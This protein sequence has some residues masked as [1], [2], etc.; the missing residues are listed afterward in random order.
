VC[1]TNTFNIINTFNETTF[2]KEIQTPTYYDVEY[3]YCVRNKTLHIEIGVCGLVDN[4]EL[5]ID[6]DKQLLTIT[7]SRVIRQKFINDISNMNSNRKNG[8]FK[9]NCMLSENEMK[10][11]TF[12]KKSISLE[13]GVLYI[14][15][16]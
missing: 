11:I 14:K 16:K 2:P 7:G 15:I 6:N 12:T 10:M 5:E 3:S 9:V 13:E 4:L 1:N 8:M